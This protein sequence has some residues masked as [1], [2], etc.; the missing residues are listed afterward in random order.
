MFNISHAC[1]SRQVRRRY[2]QHYPSLACYF[3][4]T[5]QTTVRPSERFI[6]RPLQPQICH[7]LIIKFAVDFWS[8]ITA[9]RSEIAQSTAYLHSERLLERQEDSRCAVD[10]QK[11]T[12]ERHPFRSSSQNDALTIGNC[13]DHYP[14]PLHFD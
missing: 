6:T 4:V 1:A 9:Q 8:G 5:F 12:P 3:V 2:Q 11:I 7:N 13:I 14:S 10:N